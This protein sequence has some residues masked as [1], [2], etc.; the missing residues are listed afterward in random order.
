[1]SVANGGGTKQWVEIPFGEVSVELKRYQK[2]RDECGRALLETCDSRL[3]VV[4]WSDSKYV[5]ARD[6]TGREW[7]LNRDTT[8]RDIETGDDGLMR[9]HHSCLV[10]RECIDSFV[11]IPPKDGQNS[12]GV[13]RVA[14]Y[15][16]RVARGHW[17]S[18]MNQRRQEQAQK[19]SLTR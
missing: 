9:V 17:R 13:V 16:Y 18:L 6:G 10:R 14:G 5:S 19:A 15:D 4:F 11:R 3:F 12:Y 2:T 1:M 7:L 8:L